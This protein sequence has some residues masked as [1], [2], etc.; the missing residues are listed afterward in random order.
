MAFSDYYCYYFF[1]QLSKLKYMSEVCFLQK[2]QLGSQAQLHVV[3]LTR[4]C[5]TEHFQ[6][7]EIS[8]PESYDIEMTGAVSDASI[9]GCNWY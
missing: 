8:Q 5:T 1:F 4:T 2:P 3:P 7:W 9:F 6:L